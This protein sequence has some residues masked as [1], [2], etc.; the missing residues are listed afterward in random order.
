MDK[1]EKLSSDSH[2]SD[3]LYCSGQDVHNDQ[4]LLYTGLILHLHQDNKGE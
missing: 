1:E 4:P 3:F 2:F